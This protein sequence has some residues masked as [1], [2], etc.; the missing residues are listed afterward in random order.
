MPIEKKKTHIVLL[1]LHDQDTGNPEADAENHR[2]QPYHAKK[3][4]HIP[5]RTV[6]KYADMKSL[7]RTDIFA[8]LCKTLGVSVREILTGEK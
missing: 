5:P 1:F 4:G 7:P 3:A 8:N 2:V 6:G